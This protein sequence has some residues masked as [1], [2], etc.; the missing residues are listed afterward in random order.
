LFSTQE[1]GGKTSEKLLFLLRTGS[2]LGGGR[3]IDG[4]VGLYQ[5]GQIADERDEIVRGG[6]AG[7]QGSREVA[8][9]DTGPAILVD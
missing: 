1:T 7:G 5:K 2:N 8:V 3:D 6:V 9:R 4:G